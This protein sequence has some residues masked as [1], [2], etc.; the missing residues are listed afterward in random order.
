[1]KHLRHPIKS[2][3]RWKLA[4]WCR[5]VIK[6]EANIEYHLRCAGFNRDQV[7]SFRTDLVKHRITLT[8]V[9]TAIIEREES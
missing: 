5:R 8:Q 2:Y 6:A 9:L 1:M 4:L 7:R 3:R